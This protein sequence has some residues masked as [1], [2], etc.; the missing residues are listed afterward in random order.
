MAPGIQVLIAK[1]SKVIYEK[2]FGTFKYDSIKNVNNSSFFDLA[3]LTKMLVTTP[4]I[5]GLVDENIITLDSKIGDLIPRYKNSNKSNIS[6]KDLLSA[7]ASIKPWI[8]FYSQTLD[9][10]G[11]PKKS[12]Y[13]LYMI[14]YIL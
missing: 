10:I 2:S 12:L 14:Q 5:M 6:V 13:C 4:I 1:D 8:P 9:S 3:S 7:N 11:K